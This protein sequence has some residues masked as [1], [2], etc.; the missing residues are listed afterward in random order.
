MD[1]LIIG[2]IHGHADA[3]HALLAEAGFRERAGA[4]GHPAC[5]AVFVGDLIDRGPKQLAVV[6]TVRAMVDAG[7]A[8]VVLGNHEYNAIAFATPDPARPGQHCRVR[9]ARHRAQHQAFLDAVGEDSALHREIVAWFRTWP[10]W[11]ET[12]GFRAIHACWHPGA[13]AA[14]APWLG[15]DA[16]P[17]PGTDAALFSPGGAGHRA[18]E[19]LLKGPEVPLPNG[20]TYRD[21]DGQD[22]AEAR[23]RWWD[24]DARTYRAAAIVDDDLRGQIPDDE[25]PATYLLS[26]ENGRPVFFGHYWLSGLPSLLASRHA[27]LDFSVARGGYLAG[28]RYGGEQALEP[29]RLLWVAG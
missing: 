16:V 2:D 25:L 6:E 20:L 18:A 13:Q 19:T 11:L 10:F 4:W 3:L 5:R 17:R 9:N 12:A 8:S 26:D 23:L 24:R 21:K 22:R 7:T 29:G 28:Y 1:C 15:A 27:C 14:L